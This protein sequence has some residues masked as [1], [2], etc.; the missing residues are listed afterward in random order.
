MFEYGTNFIN[1]VFVT[2]LIPSMNCDTCTHVQ[3]FLVW[4]A[5]VIYVNNAI[6]QLE[7]YANNSSYNITVNV[8]KIIFYQ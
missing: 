2:D 6:E 5:N 1:I 7:R 8:Y 4:Y 3:D